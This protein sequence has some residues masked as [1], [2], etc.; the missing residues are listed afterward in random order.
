MAV[1]ASSL[2]EAYHGRDPFS[3]VHGSM[4]DYAFLRSFAT[5]TPDMDTFNVSAFD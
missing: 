1:D 4:P 5:A 3:R 2:V